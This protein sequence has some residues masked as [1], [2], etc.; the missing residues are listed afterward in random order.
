MPAAWQVAEWRE[1]L[2]GIVAGI[3]RLVADA[4]V[5]AVQAVVGTMEGGAEQAVPDAEEQRE[6]D[7]AGAPVADVVQA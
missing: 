5:G 2:A 7:V 1:Q 3:V 4:H 6:V